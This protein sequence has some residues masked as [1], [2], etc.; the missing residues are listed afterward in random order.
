MLVSKI[1]PA[2]R[3]SASVD[4]D[5]EPAFDRLA[6]RIDG[7]DD[8]LAADAIGRARE[9]FG[10]AHGGAVEGDL[11][12]AGAQ[13]V[14]HVVRARDAAAHRKRNRQLLSDRADDRVHRAAPLDRRRDVQKN[15]FVGSAPLVRAGELDRVARIRKL[16]ET[17]AFD[18]A[19]GL[20]IQARDDAAR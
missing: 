15:Q 14:A 11:V 9:D 16:D 6:A 10:I 7:E 18:D 13:Q 5:F 1:S 2:P 8:T 17:N 12:A 19:P 20:H 4:D 3:R